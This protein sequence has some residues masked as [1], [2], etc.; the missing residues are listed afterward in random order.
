MVVG[1]LFMVMFGLIQTTLSLVNNRH[2]L[3]TLNA[4]VRLLYL[5]L[6]LYVS[7]DLYTHC[8]QT[9]FQLS[10]GHSIMCM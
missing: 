4:V 8:L 10:R 7:F 3:S 6:F 1:F 9:Q 5:S 2:F